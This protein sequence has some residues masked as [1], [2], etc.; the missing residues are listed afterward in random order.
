MEETIELSRRLAAVNGATLYDKVGELKELVSQ[1]RDA[2]S[3]LNGVS[4]SLTELFAG[5]RREA[6]DAIGGLKA[7]V[8]ETAEILRQYVAVE[9]DRVLDEM[10]SRFQELSSIG[11]RV[12]K[13][14]VAILESVAGP[15]AAVEIDTDGHGWGTPTT[16]IRLADFETDQS[17]GS[18]WAGPNSERNGN[19]NG[20]GKH[21]WNGGA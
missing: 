7:D 14:E 17:V 11:K 12:L 21:S 8:G 2:Q 1:V 4:S 15:G 5:M 18:T 9:I 13:L 20:N 16:E 3:D 19:G 6:R 10:K